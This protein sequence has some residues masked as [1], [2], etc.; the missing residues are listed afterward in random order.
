LYLPNS[1]SVSPQKL[2]HHYAKNIDVRLNQKIDNL[3]DIDADHIVL[4]N[5]I[6]SL[7][8]LKNEDAFPIHT[9]RGQVS[10]LKASQQLKSL[11]TTICF[12]GY[13]SKAVEGKNA[14]GSSFQKWLEHTDI[15][16][17]DN[18]DNLARLKD[19]IPSLDYEELEIETARAGMR[20]SS[21]D[22]FPIAGKVPEKE[23][24]YIATAFGSHGIVGSIAAA[25]L[26]ADQIRGGAVSLPISSVKAL[27]A[28]RF[29]DR[30]SKKNHQK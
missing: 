30:L 15:L 8:F 12:G 10:Y 26:I 13:L 14:L 3:D 11:K 25:H 2:C 16:E 17:S 5:G 24:I 28:Q 29:I 7:S 20:V 18:E 21:K 19:N 23:N 27:S 4:A 1:G 6:G 22:R 9:V